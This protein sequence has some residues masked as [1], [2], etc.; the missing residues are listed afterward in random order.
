MLNA[1]SK[2]N[3]IPSTAQAQVD[4]RR[5][6]NETKEEVL[7]RFRQIVND[8][9]VDIALAPGPQVPATD[10]SPTTSPLY[11]AMTRAISR[12]NP[13]DVI[14]PYMSTSSTDSS[15]LRAHGMP[16]YGVPVFVRDSSDTRIHGNDERISP[17]NLEDGVELLWQIVLEIAGGGQ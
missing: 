5:L 17:K 15:F 6:P 1:G 3:V 8:P 16:V 11:L 7:A 13:K 12:S 14:S 10:P 4:V 9:S 2:N